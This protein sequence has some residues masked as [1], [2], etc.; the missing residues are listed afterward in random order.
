MKHA[1]VGDGEPIK[2]LEGPGAE[3]RLRNLQRRF[4][5]ASSAGRPQAAKLARLGL[6]TF[7]AMVVAGLASPP[8][9]DWL[10]AHT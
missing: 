7:V 10:A 2:P 3:Q 1:A 8:L 6:L 5:A 4:R 9:I